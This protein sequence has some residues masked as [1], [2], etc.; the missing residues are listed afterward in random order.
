MIIPLWESGTVPLIRQVRDA[1]SESTAVLVI[2]ENG[3][4]L[5]RSIGT[6]AAAVLSW[7][8]TVPEVSLAVI[9][10]TTGEPAQARRRPSADGG[11]GLSG[12]ELEVMRLAAEGLTNSSAARALHL[13][14][15]TV[16]TYWR[17]VFRKLDVHDRTTAV[18]AAISAGALPVRAADPA[19][20]PVSPC[21]A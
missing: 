8:A 21:P 13:S 9:A 20:F 10:A 1:S 3:P 12:R 6:G 16:K 7:R 15:A 18:A 19:P 11:L 5:D 17:R 4:L 14:E 2:G